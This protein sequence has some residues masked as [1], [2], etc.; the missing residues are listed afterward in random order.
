MKQL[1]EFRTDYEAFSSIASTVNRQ[2]GFAGIAWLW[3]F[4]SNLLDQIISLPRELYFAGLM[5][6]FSLFFDLLQYVLGTIVWFIFWRVKEKSG[7]KT[8]KDITAPAVLTWIIWIP[9]WL[10]ILSMLIGYFELLQFLFSH[11]TPT[12]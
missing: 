12:K 4:K 8:N 7:V 11:I 10:K 3:I 1:Q 5:I 2:L 9:F 6:L